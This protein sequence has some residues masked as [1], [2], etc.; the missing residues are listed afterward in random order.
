MGAVSQPGVSVGTMQQEEPLFL[1]EMALL[2]TTVPQW[3]PDP[4]VRQASGRIT[5]VGGRE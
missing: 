1:S 2:G 5:E 3:G 4:P